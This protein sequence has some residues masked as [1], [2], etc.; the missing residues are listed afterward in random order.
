MTILARSLHPQRKLFFSPF[1]TCLNHYS[2]RSID[3]IVS[4]IK[5]GRSKQ[6]RS[7]A[8]SSKSNS[9]TTNGDTPKTKLKKSI[10]P[11][12]KKTEDQKPVESK[13]TPTAEL[14]IQLRELLREKEIVSTKKNKKKH[15]N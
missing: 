12:E 14:D 7:S 6:R 1:L 11:S 13:S 5:C 4:E 3:A 2:S 10:V 9:S 8:I 15:T